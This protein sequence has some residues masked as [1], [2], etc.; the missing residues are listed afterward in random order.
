MTAPV[1]PTTTSSQ[2]AVATAPAARQGPILG[3]QDFLAMLVAQLRNQDPLS[4]MDGAEY[5]AQLAQFSTVEQLLAIGNKLDA[6]A[7][8]IAESVLVGQ[9]QMGSALIGREVTLR[10][11]TL[12]SDGATPARLVLELPDGAR[13]V[14]IEVLDATGKRV[15]VQ[16]FGP[17]HAGRAELALDSLSLAAGN[18]TTKVPA[19]GADGAAAPA[20]MFTIGR[21]DGMAFVNGQVALRINGSLIPMLDI[22][23]IMSAASAPAPATP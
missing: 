4:P 3:K 16:T 10:G 11:A 22:V 8:Q 18:Y 20:E 17:Q 5:A 14:E 7:G 21:V 12:A 23:E 2:A 1:I 9:T 15:G 19:N 6:Q 13:S